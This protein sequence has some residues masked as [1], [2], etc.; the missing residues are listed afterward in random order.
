[1]NLILTEISLKLQLILQ[2][3]RSLNAEKVEYDY[4]KFK[5]RILYDPVQFDTRNEVTS[6]FG[7]Q[8]STKSQKQENYFHIKIY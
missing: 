1:L 7:I 2:Q 3:S 6:Q 4:F 8:E 5:I